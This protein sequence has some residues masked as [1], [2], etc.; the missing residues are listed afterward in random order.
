MFDGVKENNR[1]SEISLQFER[2][3]S[4]IQGL[5]ENVKILGNR[6]A[7]IRSTPL[8]ESNPIGGAL[9]PHQRPKLCDVAEKIR[10]LSEQVESLTNEIHQMLDT[11]EL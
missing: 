10:L 7:P 4:Q 2:L 9:T 1:G 8:N 3:H 5:T 6:L 11:V